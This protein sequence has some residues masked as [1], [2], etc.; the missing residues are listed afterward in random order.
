MPSPEENAGVVTYLLSDRACDVT[1]QVVRVDH[2][3]LSIMSHPA[4]VA[5]Q[6][7]SDLTPDGISTAFDESLRDAFQPVGISLVTVEHHGNVY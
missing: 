1:G 7:P 6:I 2:G 3:K 5:P 4:V